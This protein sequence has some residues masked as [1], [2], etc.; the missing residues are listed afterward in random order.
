MESVIERLS[1]KIGDAELTFE[2]GRIAKQAQGSV[3]VTSGETMVLS[4]VT[5]A[6]TMRPGQDFFPMTVDYREKSFA[7]GHIPG[8]FFRRE[9]RPSEREILICR[10]T[11][12][13]IRPLFPK[14]FLNELQVCQTVF[15][16]DN[17]N[18]PDVLSIN[19]ASAALHI[20]KVPFMGPIGAVRVGLIDG[21]L[22][23]MPTID[24][25][26]ES[27]LDIIMA[28]TR[29]AI[30]MVEGGAEQLPEAKILEALEFGHNYIKDICDVI[31]KLR[32]VAGVEKM[33]VEP[34]E[35]DP[36]LM[37]DVEA[38]LVEKYKEVLNVRGK[39]EHCLLYTSPSPRD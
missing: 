26:E 18:D 15:S 39:H 23:V 7:A 35:I 33:T 31:D 37:Q 6:D 4:A 2:T 9:A 24:Q 3:L 36:E 13:P 5:V 19:A 27:D 30:T 14:E 21:Q 16:A 10:V 12:R 1:V 20:S 34:H 8:N 11:D 25:M 22:V 32:A 38:L 17:V 28:G 29:D